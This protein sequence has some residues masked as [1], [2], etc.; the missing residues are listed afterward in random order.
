MPDDVTKISGAGLGRWLLL[1][2]LILIGIVLYFRFAPT[3][4]PVV[5]AVESESTP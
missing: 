4:R 3:V 1:A 2:V 5:H